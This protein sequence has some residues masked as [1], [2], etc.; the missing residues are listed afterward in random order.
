MKDFVSDQSQ[1]IKTFDSS[2]S[3]GDRKIIHDLA[4]QFGSIDHSSKGNPFP[5]LF[6][7]I[8]SSKVEDKKEHLPFKKD[9]N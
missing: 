4:D 3:F 2:T 9:I 5:T 6:G 7:V 1:T 8:K